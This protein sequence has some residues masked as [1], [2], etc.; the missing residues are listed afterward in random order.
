MAASNESEFI[1]KTRRFVTGVAADPERYGLTRD[2][3]APLAD[4]AAQYFAAAP[5]SIGGDAAEYSSGNSLRTCAKTAARGALRSALKPIAR[6]VKGNSAV[7]NV[8]RAELGLPPRPLTQ[9]EKWRLEAQQE[10]AESADRAA[11]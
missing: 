3:V 2:A 10:Q 5:L 6:A 1:A 11:A 8:M 4:A 9:L 7:T